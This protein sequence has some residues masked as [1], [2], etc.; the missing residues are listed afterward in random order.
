M[1]AVV[2]IRI[3]Q[4]L[5]LTRTAFL[6]ELEMENNENDP[7]ENL[8]LVLSIS[9]VATGVPTTSRFSIGELSS[10]GMKTEIALNF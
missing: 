4:R 6:V 5:T 1:C 10:T 2:K 3:R 8:S 9:E 7:L